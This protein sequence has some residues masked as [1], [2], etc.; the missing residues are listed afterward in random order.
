MNESEIRTVAAW[1]DLFS[2][3]VQE[4]SEAPTPTHIMGVDAKLQIC[5][6]KLLDALKALFA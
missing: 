4:R 3:M 1:A 5:A 6:E 2:K